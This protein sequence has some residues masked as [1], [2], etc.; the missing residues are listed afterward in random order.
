ME[1]TVHV[2]DALCSGALLCRYFYSTQVFVIL[3][4]CIVIG[5]W[6]ARPSGLKHFTLLKRNNIQRERERAGKVSLK[7]GVPDFK[8]EFHQKCICQPTRVW[9]LSTDDV[10]VKDILGPAGMAWKE[11]VSSHFYLSTLGVNMLTKSAA[12][13]F[14]YQS[15]QALHILVQV[16]PALSEYGQSELL[17]NSKFC[18]NYIS[19]STMQFCMLNLKFD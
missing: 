16:G 19:I 5:R 4:P 12:K 7:L 8:I 17:N 18:G 3:T 9:D 10:K 2:I 1:W 6:N 11:F 15:G 14:S 13:R